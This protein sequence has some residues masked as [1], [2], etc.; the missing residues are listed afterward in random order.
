MVRGCWYIY[1]GNKKGQDE[2]ETSE[3]GIALGTKLTMILKTLV[4]KINNILMQYFKSQ[5]LYKNY[6]QNILKKKKRQ[7]HYRFFLLPQGPIWLNITL[8]LIQTLLKM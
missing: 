4:I 7:Q 5:S 8:L 2:D 3:V 6:E 1:Q